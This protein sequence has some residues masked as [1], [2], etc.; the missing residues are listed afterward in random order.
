[1]TCSAFIL[2]TGNWIHKICI[3]TCYKYCVKHSFCILGKFYV[4]SVKL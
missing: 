3:A 1:M 2:I 4:E